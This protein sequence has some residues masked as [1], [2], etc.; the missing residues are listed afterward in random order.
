MFVCDR[1]EWGEFSLVAL[2]TFVKVAAISSLL[3]S[4][5]VEP[6]PLSSLLMKPWIH[7]FCFVFIAFTYS[8][9][10]ALKFSYTSS[11][12]LSSQAVR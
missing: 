12:G 1:D 2:S 11:T 10:L 9:C 8:F 4:E 7:L 5:D 6:L 3:V